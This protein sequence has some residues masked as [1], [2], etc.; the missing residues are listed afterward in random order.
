MVDQ[1][2]LGG[3]GFAI[4][5]DLNPT[6]VALEALKPLGRETRKHP[7]A[8]IRK[9]QAS[10]K[11][12]GFVVPVVIDAAQRVVA[13]HGLVLAARELGFK[14]VPAVT[15]FDLDE[16]KLRALR[17]A[18]NR[19]GEDSYWEL[20][21]VALEFSDILKIDGEIDL[22][23][24]GFEMGEI[25]VLLEGNGN[26][27]EDDFA[28][29]DGTT[30]C[31]SRRGDLWLLGNHRL[32]CGDALATESYQRLLGDERAEMIFAD[33]PWNIL[34]EGNVSGLGIVKHKNFAMA[35]GEMTTAEFE[36]FLATSLGHAARY[37][38]DGSIH[39]VCMHWT[40]LRE[41]LNAT[42]AIYSELKNVCV[43]NKSNAG[44]GSLYRS[45]HELVF[46]FKNG[47]CPHINNIGLGRHGRHRA[48]VWDYPGQNAMDRSSKGKLALH[49]TAKPV[50][51]V[52]DAI[53]D[54]SNRSGIVLDPFGGIGTT[55]IAAEKAGRNARLIEIDP[56]YLDTTIMRWQR[57][58]G[59]AALR[60]DTQR[61]F[62]ELQLE[63]ARLPGPAPDPASQ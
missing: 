2:M 35:A 1:P 10:I 45:K 44:M 58:T 63:A 61:S 60:A 62:Q 46:V 57:L 38:E 59:R 36:S 11:E 53:R 9:L 56:R 25:D 12:F 3:N 48:N 50:A 24:S 30:A 14:E 18:L 34:I 32:F 40:K 6:L 28:G 27:E 33:P 7:P 22:E 23:L 37:S 39:F 43:W 8:Q 4:S 17:L 49:P 5:R 47:N 15:I 16:A 54:C 55:L 21:A 51:L 19:L 26:D 41:L 29:I 20:D 31:T 42:K 13:G 52:M